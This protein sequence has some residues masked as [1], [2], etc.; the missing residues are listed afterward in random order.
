M[1]I[2]EGIDDAVVTLNRHAAY[3]GMNRAA[4]EIF[5]RLGHEPKDMV[6]KLVWEVFPEAKGTIV[7][8]EVWRALNLQTHA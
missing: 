3:V 6:G 7:E 8:R 1:A 5:R 4:A 2:L